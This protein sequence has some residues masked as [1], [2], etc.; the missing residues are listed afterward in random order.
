MTTSLPRTKDKISFGSAWKYGYTVT[1]RNNQLIK[2][3]IIL[4]QDAS[5][6]ASS[7]LSSS[8]IHHHRY[9]LNSNMTDTTYNLQ[10]LLVFLGFTIAVVLCVRHNYAQQNHAQQMVENT[11]GHQITGQ[12]NASGSVVTSR[13]ED[14]EERREFILTN[15]VVEPRRTQRN[16]QKA[17]G[18]RNKEEDANRGLVAVAPSLRNLFQGSTRILKGL[19]MS[20]LQNDAICT[21]CLEGHKE[22]DEIC[23][24]RNK[25]CPHKFHLDCMVSWLMDHDDCPVCRFPYLVENDEINVNEMEL[26]V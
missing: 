24:S 25:L 19:S 12:Q 23:S 13:L 18:E 7:I 11:Q 2:D 3:S 6:K 5:N 10:Y 9:L 26:P 17:E 16:S 22:K 4:V 8:P 1:L 14:R 15:V 20:S 21:I